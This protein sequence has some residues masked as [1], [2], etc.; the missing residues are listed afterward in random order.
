[1]HPTAFKKKKKKR[2]KRKEDSITTEFVLHKEALT[3]NLH[4]FL[5]ISAPGLQ[6]QNEKCKQMKIV[7]KPGG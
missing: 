7:S 4:N 2:R 1:M 5:Y 6:I 3:Y